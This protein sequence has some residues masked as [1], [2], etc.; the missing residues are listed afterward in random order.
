MESIYYKREKSSKGRV[1][2]VLAGFLSVALIVIFVLKNVIP[3][4]DLKMIGGF[5]KPGEKDNKKYYETLIN[6]Y[7]P[8]PTWN[9]GGSFG[10]DT[11]PE[12]VAENAILVDLDSGKVLFE[13]DS[14]DVKEI[15]SLVKIMTAVVA[16]EH[17]SLDHEITISKK[18]AGI[19]ENIMGISARERYSLEE[20]LYGLLLP[21][22]NDAAFAISEGVAGDVDTF[23]TWMNLKSD[24]LGLKNTK[25]FDPSGLDDTTKSSAAD[26]IKLAR[27]AMKNPK[28]RK[29][30]G[31][32][33]IELDP[34]EKHKY[35]YLWNQTN[36]LTTYPG[37]EGIKTGFTEDSGLC[38]VTY[39]KK[40]GKE[41]IGVVLNSVDR[42]GDMILMLDHGFSTLGVSVEHS[43]L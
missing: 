23:V 12:V 18:A 21:S 8:E 10:T 7:D 24:E 9:P 42:K 6:Y 34:S 29:V 25:F 13:K 43:L 26:L 33:E 28:F 36:L 37:V 16:L 2:V 20:L 22:G 5:I 38:L 40:D 17:K 39:A 32:Y 14:K 30:V 31:T 19:G 15:A 41:V 11:A 35:I 3:L 4:G 1:F 27:Y